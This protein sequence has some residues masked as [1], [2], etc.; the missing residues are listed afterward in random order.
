MSLITAS[1]S[2]NHDPLVIDQQHREFAITLD[3]FIVEAPAGAGKTE[4]LTQRFLRL[5]TQV[6]APEE[7]IAITFTN[8]AASEMRQR[9]LENLESAAKR[10]WPEAKHR[11]LTYQLAEA[12]L[13]YGETLGWQLLETPS[14]LRIYT[15]DA[16]CGNL[17]RQMPLLSR[18]GTQPSVVDDAKRH[19]SYVASHLLTQL[20]NPDY[21]PAVIT[22]LRFFDN[23][24]Q[25]LTELLVSMLGRREQ[26]QS[27]TGV[28]VSHATAR[29]ALQTMIKSS[30]ATVAEAWPE[31]YQEPLMPLVRFAASQLPPDHWIAPLRDWSTPLS[32]SVECLADWKILAQFLLTN[33]NKL[34]KLFNVN[35]GFPATAEA[36]PMKERALDILSMFERDSEAIDAMGRVRQLPNIESADENQAVIQALTQLLRVS[37][38]QLWLRFQQFREVDFIEVSKSALHALRESTGESTELAMRLDY[39]IQHLLVDEFQDTSP[40]QVQLLEALT[41]GWQRQDGRTLFCVGDPMQS[42][43]RFRKAEVGEFLR[44]S[45]EGIGDVA[46]TPLKLWRNNRSCPA[47]VDWINHCFARLFPKQDQPALGAIRYRDFIATRSEEVGEGVFVHPFFRRQGKTRDEDSEEQTVDDDVRLQEAERII[48][49]IQHT[50]QEKPTATI[51]VL[52]RARKHLDTLVSLIRRNY[53]ELSFQ[54]VEIEQLTNR[55]IVQDLLSLTNSLMQLADRVNWLAVLRAPWC[56]LTLADLHA[57]AGAN[58]QATILSLLTNEAQL[59]RLSPDGQI[60]ARHVATVMHQAIA[61]RGR[62]STRRWIES[63]WLLLGGAECLWATNDVQDVQAFFARIDALEAKGVFTAEALAEDVQKL[64]AAPDAKAD[65]SL[66]FMTIHKSKG[67]E[68]DTVILPGLDSS[69]PPADRALVLWEEV[70]L[71]PNGSAQR[72]LIAA[73]YQPKGIRLHQSN[74]DEVNLYDYLFQIEKQRSRFEDARVLYV[75]ATR[76]IRCLHLLGAA[77]LKAADQLTVKKDSFLSLLWPTVSGEF[78]KVF[79]QASLQQS[80]TSRNVNNARLMANFVPKLIR[81][82]EPG[83]PD[84]FKSLGLNMQ[85]S[86]DAESRPKTSLKLTDDNLLNKNATNGHHQDIEADIG[87]LTH[88]YLQWIAQAYAHGKPLMEWSQADKGLPAYRP[89]MQRWF[90]QRGHTEPVSL[91]SSQRVVNLLLNALQSEDGQWVLSPHP[92]A[93]SEWVMERVGQQVEESADVEKRIIDRTFLFEGR[94]WI[95]DYKTAAVE[96]LPINAL[97][98]F[99]ERYRTQLEGYA[100][101]FIEPEPILAVFFVGIGR[102]VVLK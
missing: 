25:Q 43:Y 100:S 95:I 18:F 77:K 32:A 30:L 71:T 33:E 11:Q 49:I 4:L 26:W 67:L 87:T 101:Y 80:D 2:P 63:T 68:F 13:T 22:A 16:L 62:Q 90:Q 83:L 84:L 45:T 79:Q 17:A 57:L 102:L 35:L 81:L 44:V 91:Q 9:I 64:Y 92:Q 48:Q 73:A 7:I 70:A 97:Q 36:K 34:R 38:A 10:A 60:R 78:T 61:Q 55:Q 27:Y 20:N 66:Q 89:S 19:Y 47:I 14:R 24:Q 46:L 51:A 29:Q 58:K 28:S 39:Q 96:N 23:N 21:G 50:R 40:V 5:L 88:L 65:A 37:L 76:A 8:K 12:A 86:K 31:R 6:Q 53:P 15:I 1:S 52:V 41:A 69:P 93:V 59:Q 75:A 85:S 72:G 42:I 74:D 3:S 99:A 98:E 94:R 56:G 54:A 82:K